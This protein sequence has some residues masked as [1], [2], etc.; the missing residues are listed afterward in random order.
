MARCAVLLGSS[1]L[2]FVAA[3]RMVFEG[4]D[5]RRDLEETSVYAL[6]SSGGLERDD[7]SI[8]THHSPSFATRICHFEPA[9]RLCLTCPVG[10]VWNSQSGQDRTIGNK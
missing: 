3:E 8:A 5:R 6:Y 4:L 9:L 7:K 1:L 2:L 10:G